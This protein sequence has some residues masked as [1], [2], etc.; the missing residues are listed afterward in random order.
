MLSF[1]H[2]CSSFSSASSLFSLFWT[3]SVFCIYILSSSGDKF[4]NWSMSCNLWFALTWVFENV[5]VSSI[6]FHAT[7]FEKSFCCLRLL[8]FLIFQQL[9]YFCVALAALDSTFAASYGFLFSSLNF[10]VMLD[11]IF[12]GTMVWYCFYVYHYLYCRFDWL[13]S[14]SF[15]DDESSWGQTWLWLWICLMVC[16]PETSAMVVSGLSV[17][18]WVDGGINWSWQGWVL[19]K[20]LQF[21][22]NI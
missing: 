1:F 18:N 9:E 22:M 3:S 14:L 10:I 20:Q 16:V 15:S 17:V 4:Y 11:F 7:I 13:Y 8:L 2:C 19:T 5:G 21:L 12:V 6:I